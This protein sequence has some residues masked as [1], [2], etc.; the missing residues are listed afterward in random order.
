[1]SDAMVA[2]VMGADETDMQQAERLMA[3]KIMQIG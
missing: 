1:M 2:V 3:S